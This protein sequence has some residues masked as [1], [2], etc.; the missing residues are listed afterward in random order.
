MADKRMFSKLIVDSDAFLD[1]PLSTQALYFHLS[2][3][4]DDE[5]FI[6]N[7]KKIMRMISASQNELEI[8]IGKR[9]ILVFDSG[10][11]VIKHWK[12]HN[13][14]RTD[15][16]KPTVNSIE[17]MQLV[18]KDNGSYT[19]GQA[20][21][22]QVSDKCPHSTV[23]ISIDKISN[24]TY[25]L[26][27]DYIEDIGIIVDD[28]VDKFNEAFIKQIPD[29]DKSAIRNSIYKN[30]KAIEAEYITI[31]IFLKTVLKRILDLASD[32]KKA[33][34]PIG[35][36]VNYFFKGCFGPDKYLW[37]QTRQEENENKGGYHKPL[38]RKFEQ[39]HSPVAGIKL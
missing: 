1:M 7:P 28:F 21:V 9:F 36:P 30:K 25:S 37:R 11:I 19:E 20:D 31:E 26:P 17:R 27:S 32:A 38:M 23:Q 33:G 10:V 34:K 39:E 24:N 14:I 13:W 5:G 8:L 18:I 35:M 12:I 16:I 22:R 4:A 6:N 2:M 15:R 29:Q 3:R